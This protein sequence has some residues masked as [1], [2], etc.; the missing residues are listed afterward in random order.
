MTLN[1]PRVPKRVQNKKSLFNRLRLKRLFFRKLVR[2]AAGQAKA[3]ASSA[4]A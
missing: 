4:G 3:D 2:S 1:I